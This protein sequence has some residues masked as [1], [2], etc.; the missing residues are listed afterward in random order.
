MNKDE[1]VI[2]GEHSYNDI[3]RFSP[4]NEALKKLL[5]KEAQIVIADKEDEYAALA[6]ALGGK[7]ITLSPNSNPSNA[8]INPFTDLLDNGNTRNNVQEQYFVTGPAR[9]EFIEKMQNFTPKL[10]SNIEKREDRILFATANISCT[11]PA[12]I[13]N[14]MSSYI[15]LLNSLSDSIQIKKIFK[16]RDK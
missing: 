11:S 13:N 15:D 10:I 3:G 14:I 5:R 4:K 7:V 16:E 12:E 9:E 2:I 1:K 8:Y 6:R